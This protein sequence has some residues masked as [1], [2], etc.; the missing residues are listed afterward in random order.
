MTSKSWLLI[1]SLMASSLVAPTPTAAQTWSQLATSGARPNSSEAVRTTNY[2]SANNRLIVFLP[3]GSS[4]ASQV[5]ALTHANGLG[6]TPTWTQLQPTGTGPKNNGGSTAVYDAPANQLI[7]Y[8]GCGGSCSPALPDVF[9]LTNANGLGGTPA[10]SQRSPTS[11]IARANQAAVYDPTTNS[12][13]T[14]G[15]GLAFFGTDQ[16]DTHVLFPANSSSPTWTTLSPTGGLPSVRESASAVYETNLNKMI[17]FGGRD[18]I[19]SCCPYNIVDYNDVWVLSNANGHGG[20]PEWTELHP[21][22]NPPEPRGDHSAVYDVGGNTMYVFGGLSWSNQT[23]RYTV[24]GDVWRLSN[25]DGRGV[26]APT[27]T[28]VGQLGTPPGA[29]ADQGAAYDQVNGRMISYGG[30]DRNFVV[31]FLTFILDFKQH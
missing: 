7:V 14:F 19:S 5:W 30:Q 11:A 23:Q 18:A 16:N 3:E 4:S 15:G 28:Q 31:N 6:G 29:N 17:I 24:L 13:I 12:M 8:G 27:W 9:V 2:D 22:G 21:Q 10:W 20:T 1:S 25:A 26:T